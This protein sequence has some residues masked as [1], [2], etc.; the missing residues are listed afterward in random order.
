MKNKKGIVLIIVGLALII[1]ALSLT[2]Y[3]KYD[4]KRAGAEAQK[5]LQ[6]IENSLKNEQTDSEPAYKIE[7]EIQMPSVNVDGYEYIG[8]IYFPT[9]DLA[10]P[11]IS[12]VGR[13]KLKKAPCRYDGSVYTDD[14]IIAGHN[15]IT[16]FGRINRL[17]YGDEVIFTDIDKNEFRYKVIGTEIIDGKNAAALVSGE[18]DLTLFT[19]TM[20]GRSRI[21]V[22]CEKIQ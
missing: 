13:K 14:M 9:L 1:G 10:L 6:V 5:A 4:E 8:K 15:Y 12:D 11:V 2:L 3:N 19:C 18:W 20:S 16:H 21:T 7:N 22:R 17:K